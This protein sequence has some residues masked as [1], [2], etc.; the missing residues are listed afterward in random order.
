[1]KNLTRIARRSTIAL[2]LLALA[3]P[4]TSVNASAAQLGGASSLN[5]VL[6]QLQAAREIGQTANQGA[7][8]TVVG[9]D[10]PATDPVNVQAAVTQ[11]FLS[12][13]GTVQLIGT[14]NFGA[15]SFCVVVPGPITISGVGDP[16]V[17]DAASSPATVIKASGMAPFAILDTGGPLGNITI[18]RIWFN[19]AQTMAVMLLQIRGTFNFLNN[20]VSG[21][22]PGNQFRFAVAGAAV[23]PVPEAD[24]AAITAAFTRLGTLNGP[25]LTG[26]VIYDSNV[27]SNEIPMPAGDDNAFAFAQCHLSRIQITNNVIL[28]GEAV[29]IEGCRGPGAVYIVENN[30]ITQT[31]TQSNMA[32][33]T[34]SP[35]EIRRGGHPAAI[36]PLDS[37]AALVI[38]RNNT[39]DMRKAPPTAVCMLTGNSNEESLT[40]IE[41]NTCAINRQF[42]VL[43]G[44]WAGTPNFFNP[45]YMQNA[46]IRDN[47]FLGIAHLGIALVN[48]TY[49]R[50]AEMTLINKGRDNIAY[51]NDVRAF[52]AVRAAVDLGIATRDNIIIDIFRGR[53]V[54][55]G[56]S[57][58]IDSK[59]DITNR[60]DLR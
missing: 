60:G 41:G 54:N 19:G 35:G 37:E 24:S 26:V 36:K 45:S 50:N 20:R 46:V 42:A 59:Q 22:M 55:R 49:L 44:G 39:V 11:A 14:F 57:N 6:D 56:V 34:K 53:I 16:S 15:C 1:V 3:I 27:I 23:G 33:L 13:G 2:T 47:R 43:L 38:I 51:D 52:R 25:K 58:T 12:V 40:L 18:E 8:I 4:V 28:A 10:N 17:T 48:F 32:Q 29:E 7:V 31:S 5:A 30:R 21:I 9:Q